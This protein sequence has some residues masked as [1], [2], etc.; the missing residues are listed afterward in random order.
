MCVCVAEGVICIFC[1][2]ICIRMSVRVCLGSD[3][4]R[5]AA[6]ALDAAWYGVGLHAAGRVDGVAEESVP[7][8]GRTQRSRVHDPQRI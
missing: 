3:K 6:G 8:C 1:M 5:G 4:F 7:V 2:H